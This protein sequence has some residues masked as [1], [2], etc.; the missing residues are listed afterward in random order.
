[1]GFRLPVL[2][3]NFKTYAESTG[4]NAVS[5]AKQAEEVVS[6]EGA[7]VAL[8]VQAVDIRLVTNVTT[9]P[10]FAQ[11][12]DPVSYG[13]NTGHVLPEAVKAAGAIGVVLNHAENKRDNAFLER[14]IVRAKEVGL[15]VMVCAEDID[16][17][18]QVAS[19]EAKPDL[20]AVEPP[21][22]IGGD[23]SVSAARPELITDSVKAVKAIAPNIEVITGA[24]IKNEADVR[25]AVELGTRGVFVA[26]GVIKAGDQK[27]AIRGLVRGLK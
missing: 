15:V 17:A 11:H 19:F 23:V 2:F 4:S 26:S 9:L 10:V 14:A 18:R 22:L 12:V 8:V 1:M 5:L 16:R 6:E 13:S 20:I 7:S 21:E 3:L 24:G 27:E 25:K